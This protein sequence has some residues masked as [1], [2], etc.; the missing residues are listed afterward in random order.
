[1]LKR[2]DGKI[3]TVRIEKLSDADQQFIIQSDSARK[4]RRLIV[5]LPP[6]LPLNEGELYLRLYVAANKSFVDKVSKDISHA[7]SSSRFT[8]RPV[9][10]ICVENCVC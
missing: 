10:S 8:C 7:T 6:K 5:L 2:A 9:N 1:M 3:I 4:G